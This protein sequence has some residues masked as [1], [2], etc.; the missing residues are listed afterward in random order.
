MQLL[1]RAIRR[2]PTYKTIAATAR[3]GGAGVTQWKYL[4]HRNE[5]FA[6]AYAQYIF[7]RSG[8]QVMIEQLDAI[9]ADGD[10]TICL[11]HWPHEEFLPIVEAFDVL[12]EELGW[13]SRT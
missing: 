10:P 13:L 12:F 7:W 6:R 11:E 1:M 8:D 4:R 9:L 3:A 2:T 5:I